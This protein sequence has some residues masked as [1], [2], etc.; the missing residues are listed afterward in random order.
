MLRVDFHYWVEGSGYSHSETFD[1]I[2]EGMTAEEYVKA[3]E[4]NVEFPSNTNVELYDENDNLVSEFFV[5]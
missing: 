1:H 4:G 2:K 3:C 5:D